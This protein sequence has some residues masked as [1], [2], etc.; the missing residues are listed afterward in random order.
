GADQGDRIQALHVAHLHVGQVAGGQEQVLGSVLGDDQRALA[1]LV[2]GQLLDQA[3]GL[4]RVDVERLDDLQAALA[5]ELGQDRADGR[6][7]HL[8]VDLLREAARLGREGDA[9]ADEDRSRQRAMTRT[10]ALLLLR[11]LGGAADFGAGEL[12][13]AAGAT[14]ATVR[15]YDLV[16]QVVAEIAA[17]HVVGDRQLVGATRNGEFHRASPYALLAGR[18]I[19]SPPGAPGTAP[20]TAIRPRS[21]STRT[22]SRFCVLC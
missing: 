7:V 5:V 19:T 18:T 16:A 20:R 17:E 2:T 15:D 6:A 10:A 8:A 1:Q 21:A 9:A 13:L 11:L 14:G 12:R 4:R 22:T 3:L